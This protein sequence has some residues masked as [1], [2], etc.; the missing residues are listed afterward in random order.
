MLCDGFWGTLLTKLLFSPCD[1]ELGFMLLLM[2]SNFYPGVESVNRINVQSFRDQL[3]MIERT[4]VYE[5]AFF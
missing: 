1:A 2:Y 3:I 5:K 4:L